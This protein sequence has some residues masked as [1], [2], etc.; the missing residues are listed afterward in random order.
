MATYKVI[1]D[2]E[3]EDKFLGPLTLKQFIFA[4]GGAVFGYLSFLSVMKGAPFL[5]AVFVPPMLL[6][7]FLAIPWSSEQSTEIWVL[8]KLRFLFKPKSRIWDQTGLEELVTVTVP[9]KEEKQLTFH[10]DKIQSTSQRV[11][12]SYSNT[13]HSQAKRLF[14]SATYLCEVDFPDVE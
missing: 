8:A 4:A 7:L 3:A 10:T 13:S 5:L 6:G 14:G 11:H 12:L 9:K 1:Q 2:I